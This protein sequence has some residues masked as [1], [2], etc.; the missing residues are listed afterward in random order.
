MFKISITNLINN[1]QFGANFETM[2]E[3]NEWIAKQE[4][5]A[6]SGLGWGYSARSLPKSEVPENLLPLIESEEDRITQEAY[7]VTDENGNVTTIEA[8]VVRYANLKAEY[9]I[10]TED[11]TAQYE[12]EQALSALIQAGEKD[13]KCCQEVRALIGGYNRYKNLT[14]EQLQLMLSTYANINFALQNQMPLTAKTMIN[15]ISVDD[16]ITTQE[17][18]DLINKVFDKYGIA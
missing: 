9:V 5:K 3:A 10:T 2:E 4:L 1:R 13:A 6:K 11:I 15:L 18:K 14:N 16:V 17:L 8:V 12:A 7:D